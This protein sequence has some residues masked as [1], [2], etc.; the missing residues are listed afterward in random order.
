[1]ARGRRPSANKAPAGTSHHPAAG[2][3]IVEYAPQ[4][5]SMEL[6]CQVLQELPSELARAVF[7]RSVE[8]L[9]DKL[10]DNDIY[11]LQR[12]AISFDR[13]IEADKDVE[14]HGLFQETPWGRKVNPAAKLAR[15]ESGHYMKIADQYA[16]TFVSR[17]RAGILQLAGQSMMEQ[18]HE[19]MASAIVSRILQLDPVETIVVEQAMHR[20]KCGRSFGSARG[21]SIHRS[22]AHK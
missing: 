13:S 21:L 8:A 15:D 2:E 18:I 17:L 10:V 9:G 11:A 14:A 3:Q 7:S 16:L 4:V 19:S 12:M 5:H 6:V 22:R 20:C 1:M